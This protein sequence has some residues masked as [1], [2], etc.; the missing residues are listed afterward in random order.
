MVN[1]ESDVY[2]DNIKLLSKNQWVWTKV[3]PTAKKKEK[4]KKIINY[5]KKNP[6]DY[7]SIVI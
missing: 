2:I 1:I 3:G 6:R 7:N 4:E 5:L